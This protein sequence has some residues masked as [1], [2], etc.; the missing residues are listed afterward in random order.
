[1][2]VMAVDAV[3]VSVAQRCTPLAMLNGA[4]VHTSVTAAVAD[5]A[6]VK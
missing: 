4:R 3:A 5:A 6:A 2:V 1:M